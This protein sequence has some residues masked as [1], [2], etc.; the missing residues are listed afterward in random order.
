LFNQHKDVRTTLGFETKS[1]VGLA[2]PASDFLHCIRLFTNIEKMYQETL[3]FF[4]S[5]FHLDHFL[6]VNT[7][8]ALSLAAMEGRLSIPANTVESDFLYCRKLF[9]NY[10]NFK[11]KIVDY[12]I[13]TT[14]SRSYP[15][16]QYRL[17]TP[18]KAPI[19]HPT[20]YV[21]V[22]FA[23]YMSFLSKRFCISY[24]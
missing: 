2:N 4:I 3:D 20:T 17:S 19:Q 9:M 13:L 8:S 23:L 22:V 24:K 11:Q 14:S 18:A 12:L 10:T 16:Y 15:Q 5:T 6:T 7:A 21:D 1:L